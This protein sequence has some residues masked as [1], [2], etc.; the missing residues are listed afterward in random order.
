M[1]FTS[2]PVSGVVSSASIR[3]TLQNLREARQTALEHCGSPS[4]LQAAVVDELAAFAL[5]WIA[6]DESL[7]LQMRARVGAEFVEE[8]GPSLEALFKSMSRDALWDLI[9]SEG[10]RGELGPEV[11]G[12]VIAG[13]TPLLA[14]TSAA[15]AL[16]VGGASLLKLPSDAPQPWSQM[17]CEALKNT[18]P[19]LG[20][21]VAPMAWPGADSDCTN[22]LCSEADLIV[23]YGGDETMRAV[24]ARMPQ[25]GKLIE[26]GHRVSCAIAAKEAN[27]SQTALEIAQ[28]ASLYDQGGCLSPQCVF[29]EGD[30]HEAAVFGWRVAEAFKTLPARHRSPT[31]A[32]TVTEHRLTARMAEGIILYEGPDFGWTVAIAPQTQFRV[33]CG[34]RFLYVVPGHITGIIGALSSV[35][36]RLQGICFCAG[37]DS[38]REIWTRRLRSLGDYYIATP[39]AMQC[40]PLSW[41]ENGLD[42]LRSLLL[43]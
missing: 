29:V 19:L 6:T 10:V 23:A 37:S 14:F 21:L 32:A 30:E 41:R 11:I 43:S 27:G 31:Q 3:K 34:S 39:E 36:G 25:G 28:V 38:E 24:K 5:R 13:N 16:L 1:V 8:T 26:Y 2:E 20:S 4:A 15:R 12:H 17:L 18:S 40:P 22:R 9:D 33:A 7:R 35:A 42:V